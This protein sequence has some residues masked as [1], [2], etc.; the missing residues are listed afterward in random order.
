MHELVHWTKGAARANRPDFEGTADESYAFE[1]LVAE[2]GAAIICTRFDQCIE[3]RADHAAYLK[4]WLTV[5][6]NDFD[7]FY[8]ALKL[9]QVASHWLYRKTDMAP[10]GW[11][12][13]FGEV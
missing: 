9:A 1:E 2:L 11:A 3:P 8:R 10:E 6:E 5:L 13:D 7:H 4:G 12:P